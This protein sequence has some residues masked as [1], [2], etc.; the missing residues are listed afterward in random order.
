MNK[1]RN[2]RDLAEK[3]RLRKIELLEQQQKAERER[4]R[5]E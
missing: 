1:Q 2:E 5:K 3:E 4:L